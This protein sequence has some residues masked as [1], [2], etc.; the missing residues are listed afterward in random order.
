MRWFYNMKIRARILSS[1]LIVAF[2]AG[3]IGVQG[4]FNINKISK[5]DTELY[6]KMTEPLGEL[7]NVSNAF[8]TIRVY[9]RDILLEDDP[10]NIPEIANKIKDKS[11]EFDSSLDKVSKTVLT[12]EGQEVIKD[13][14]AS[15]VKCMDVINEAVQLKLQ[16]EREKAKQLLSSDGKI[17]LNE[18]NSN[19]DKFTKLKL[20]I[21][22]ETSDNNSKIATNT[23]TITIII[24]IIGIIMAVLIGL[25][26][27]SSISKPVRKIIGIADKVADG[28][29]D[30]NIDI[31]SK[32]EIGFLATSFR[33]MT[34]RLNST[35]CT[36]N[37]AAEQVAAGSKQVSDSSIALS[38]G[39]MEQASSI[40]ELTASIE[41]ISAQTKMNADNAA[42]ANE[43]ATS[44]KVNAEDG[45]EQ[46][47]EMQRA[48][49]EINNASTSIYKII[50]VIDEIAFQ[51]NIL[52][53]NAAVEAARAGQQ[54]KGFAVVAEEVRNLAARSAKAAKETADMIEG[55]I[56]KA[57]AGTKMAN[58]TSEAL[59]RIVEDTIKVAD[60]INQ[61]AIASNE[62]A[63]GIDQ[64]NQG[65]MQV[66]TVVQTNSA[67]AEESAAASEELASQA[68]MLK[69]QVMQFN[70]K[71]NNNSSKYNSINNIDLDAIPKYI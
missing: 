55:S 54:G 15:K 14:K 60:F 52:A 53:L 8:S 42:N 30:I 39:A 65:V 33:K 23:T 70:L 68:E 21:A 58:R 49:D 34:D 46:M 25:L 6:E 2:I 26:I 29:F 13:I 40:E 44:A 61:I 22:K 12:T 17:V 27:S 19:I 9:V 7:I 16:N 57:E 37:A 69:E 31:N 62:Q 4:V 41:E 64:I 28:D 20:N 63:E 24:L 66:S 43:I 56:K 1:F 71:V 67:T 36:I 48:V 35:M 47:K 51:T 50:K 18:L 5:L 38:Q 3:V 32:D 11:N 59:N 45:Y 10:Q